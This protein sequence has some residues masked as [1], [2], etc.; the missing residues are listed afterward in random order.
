MENENHYSQHGNLIS[1]PLEEN[2]MVEV[3]V[4]LKVSTPSELLK[5]IQILQYEFHSFKDDN[6]KEIREHHELHE[7]ILQTLTKVRNMHQTKHS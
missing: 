4:N 6:I 3:N 2:L 5:T 7:E 1:P